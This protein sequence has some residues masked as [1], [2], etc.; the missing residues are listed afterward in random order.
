LSGGERGRLALCKLLL[1]PYNLLILDEPT[2][3]LDIRSKEVLKRAVLAYEGTAIIVSHDR[4]F[5]TD[6][7]EKMYEF[8]NGHV[9][10]HLG[11]IVEFM[12][13]LK[14]DRLTEMNSKS[15]FVKAK[16][17][18]KPV[19]L[20][21]PIV[22]DEREKE[23]KQIKSLITK[24]EKEIERLEG[25][26]KIFDAKLADSDQYQTLMNDKVSFANYEQLKKMLDL[27]MKN[28]ESLQAKLE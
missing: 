5:L 20:K 25:E 23:I 3:H 1:Q 7:T 8:K 24:T 11:G 26:I 13:K 19:K 16:E 27:E 10:E 15:P 9:K 2:N 18:A 12:Q 17:E 22:N 21:A 14:M 28:W 6:L 4:D